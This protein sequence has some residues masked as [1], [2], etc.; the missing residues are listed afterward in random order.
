MKGLP[1]VSVSEQE[2]PC[3]K[4]FGASSDGVRDCGRVRRTH[5]QRVHPCDPADVTM[6]GTLRFAHPTGRRD[7][8]MVGFCVGVV[9]RGMGQR[10]SVRCAVRTA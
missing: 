8:S 5:R 7:A 10:E 4:M 2:A 6:M 9:R 1:C 3:V